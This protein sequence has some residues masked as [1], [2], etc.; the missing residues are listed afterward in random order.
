MSTAPW[1]LF[2][3][4]C[5]DADGVHA[6]AVSAQSE[7]ESGAQK[8]AEAAALDE[9]GTDDEPAN[10]THVSALGTVDRDIFERFGVMAE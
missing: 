9:C 5:S 4:E 3:I 6:F 2:R 10:V 8:A 1:H 7:D